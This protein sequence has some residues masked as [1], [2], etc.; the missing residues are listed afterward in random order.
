MYCTIYL[1]NYYIPCSFSWIYFRECLPHVYITRLAFLCKCASKVCLR[2]SPRTSTCT[3]RAKMKI[4]ERQLKSK[5]E[6]QNRRAR[7]KLEERESKSKSENQTRRA[8]IKLKERES[9]T[10]SEN[11]NRRARIKLE[12]RESSKSA[13]CTNGPPYV[14][15]FALRV[16]HFNLVGGI[17]L[18]YRAILLYFVL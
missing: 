13:K 3:Q 15:R 7:I 14:S 11:Q 8:R 12:E 16:S 9:N 18:L 6:N 4:E 1:L 2:I 17:I 10:K 5:S